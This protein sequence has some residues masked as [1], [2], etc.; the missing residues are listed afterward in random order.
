MGPCRYTNMASTI[1]FVYFGYRLLKDASTMSA[2]GP[3][4]ELKE[5]E[6]E[7]IDKKDVDREDQ[8]EMGKDRDVEGGG[9]KSRGG[10]KEY[11]TVGPSQTRNM[12]IFTQALTMTF[13]AEWGELL[14]ENN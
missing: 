4:E 10:D 11:G 12:A 13:L 2:D 5:V 8:E 3:S 7:L 14:V 6:E 1:L 9:G